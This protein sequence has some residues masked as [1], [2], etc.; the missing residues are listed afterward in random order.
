MLLERRRREEHLDEPSRVT[1]ELV[2]LGR[3]VAVSD[4]KEI[5]LVGGIAVALD[6]KKR[7][8]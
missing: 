6:R 1:F 4:E 5:D 2:A 7:S 8:R 3:G